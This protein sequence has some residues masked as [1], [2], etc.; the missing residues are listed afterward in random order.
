MSSRA[1]LT[2]LY[3]P[4]YLGRDLVPRRGGAI[5]APNHIGFLDG[6]LVHA[7]SPRPVHFLVLDKVFVGTTGRLLQGA[8]QIPLAQRHGFGPALRTAAAVLERGGVV[9]IFPE[10]QR[11]RG[12][13]EE[14]YEGVAWLALLTGAPVVPVA[15]LG[16][17]VTGASAGSLPPLRSRLVVEF[18]HPQVLHPDPE[19]PGRR[20]RA[21]AMGMLRRDLVAHTLDASG[22][23]GLP[24]PED[25]P[26]DVIPDDD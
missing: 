14:V 22:R 16:T 7:A 26:A 23:H 1:A 2:S 9:G 24:L 11:G 21:Q 5:L 3:R 10:G 12:R 8:G 6:V 17:R 4:T 13:F 20:R 15:C 25:I 19:L 18:G